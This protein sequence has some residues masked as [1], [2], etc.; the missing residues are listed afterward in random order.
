MG[1]DSQEQPEPARS[2]Q[3]GEEE[4]QELLRAVLAARVQEPPRWVWAWFRS[5]MQLHKPSR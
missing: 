2:W 1:S 5:D 3:R 4:V